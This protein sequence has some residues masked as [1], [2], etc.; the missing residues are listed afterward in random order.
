[1]T[2]QRRQV[3]GDGP[4]AVLVF[5]GVVLVAAGGAMAAADADAGAVADLGVAAQRSVRQPV[6]GMGVEVALVAVAVLPGDVGQH[7][8]PWRRRRLPG[9]IVTGELGEERLGH[10]ELDDSAARPGGDEPCGAP[11]SD[12]VEQQPAR[13]VGD[14][15]SP[16]GAA[17]LG[18][19]DAGVGGGH[20]AQAGYLAGL[21]VTAEQG[22]QRHPNLHADAL[23]V[24]RGG[25]TADPGSAG[26]TL[27]AHDSIASSGRVVVGRAVREAVGSSDVV[28]DLVTAGIGLRLVVVAGSV[29]Q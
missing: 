5:D 7:A 21:L 24:T 12:A 13:G 22:G 17:L 14:G 15:E 9:P 16:L 10:V 23:V 1:M 25:I 20:G 2:A 26:D 29:R 8:R 18:D 3:R 4:A 28:A 6:A 11:T 19:D 27:V